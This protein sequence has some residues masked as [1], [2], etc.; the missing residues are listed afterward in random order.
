LFQEGG[1]CKDLKIAT[2]ETFQ[3]FTAKSISV[4]DN[5]VFIFCIQKPEKFIDFEKFMTTLSSK[6][7]KFDEHIKTERQ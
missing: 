2:I 3:L 1:D 5:R 4:V 6:N 7:I